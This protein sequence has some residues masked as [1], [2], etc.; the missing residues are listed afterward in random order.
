MCG[1]N[2]IYL[3]HFTSDRI[4]LVPWWLQVLH[5]AIRLRHELAC[6]QCKLT[7]PLDVGEIV[8]EQWEPLSVLK[9]LDSLPA[10][11]GGVTQVSLPIRWS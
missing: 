7:S 1:S 6:E 5:R 4:G 2:D 8:S 9:R 3:S 10:V 11:L